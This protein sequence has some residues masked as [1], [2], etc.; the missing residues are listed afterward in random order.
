M[1]GIAGI[2]NLDERAVRREEIEAMC[3]AIVHRGPDDE[4]FFIRDG[5]ALGMRRLSIIDLAMGHQPICN[6][7]RSVWVVFNGEIYN[8]P[9]LRQRLEQSGHRFSTNTDTEVIVHLYEEH[10]AD[11]VRHLRG[12]F[13]FAVWDTRRKQLVLGR[14]R[15]GIKPLYWAHINNRLVFASELKSILQL[16]D[17]AR[18]LNWKAVNHLFATLTTPS[19]ESI[20]AGIH[21]LEP[22]HVLTV[23]PGVSPAVTRYW[24]VNFQPDY[25][26]T[27]Q[28]LAAELR[29]RI[30]ESVRAHMIS[31]VPVGAFL[32]GG[33]DSSAV[34]AHMVRQTDKPVQTFSIGFKEESYNELPYARQIASR[35]AT[36]HHEMVLEP[37]VFSILDD[38]IWHLDEPFGDPSAIP[39]YMVSKLA[40]QNVKVVLSG[41]GGDELFAGYQKYLVEHREQKLRLPR[42][43]RAALEFAGSRMPEGMR[44]RNYIY[45]RGLTGWDRYLDA[46]TLFRTSSKARLFQPGVFA[47]F[48]KDDPLAQERGWLAQGSD[49]WLSA[50]QY[51]DLK[52]YLP[53]DILT[54]VDRMSMAHSLEVRV[55]LLDHTLVEFAATIPPELS[56]DGHGGKRVFKAAMRNILPDEVIDRSKQGFGVPL[57][58]WFR[59]E[60]EDFAHSLL[61]SRRCAQREIFNPAY[62]NDLLGR[63]RRGRPL[64][65]E[66]WTLITF[67]LWCR[68]F[69]DAREPV[70]IR[71]PLPA[72]EPAIAEGVA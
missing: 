10:G 62:L 68:R 2:V 53:L 57:G 21:K 16:D 61:L 7:D 54:K 9:A 49:R 1:C 51:L 4:G 23:R 58:H 17:V 15:L 42:A 46:S 56:L 33:I 67:E 19:S 14:D 39:T 13:G 6:E 48:A 50:I 59:G 43:L 71:E 11:L 26:S 45:H 34:V 5:V 52:T 24:D 35:F 32:S 28:D 40:A 30:E 65:F 22:A 20:I 18:R 25:R 60:L 44:G 55:P 12:M 63:H 64:D 41:D 66:L 72:F 36:A 69:L 31:D 29:G 38:L 8:F 37:D 27:P 47:E 70:P 3:S